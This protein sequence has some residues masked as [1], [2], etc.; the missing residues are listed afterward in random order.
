MKTQII[1]NINQNQV[2]EDFQKEFERIAKTGVI[3]HFSTFFDRFSEKHKALI[4]YYD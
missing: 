2:N 4:C 1:E 3:V